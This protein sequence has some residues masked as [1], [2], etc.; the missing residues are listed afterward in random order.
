MNLKKKRWRDKRKSRSVYI[1]KNI[2][3]SKKAKKQLKLPI[4][5]T[6]PIIFTSF[7]NDRKKERLENVSI[8]LMKMKKKKIVKHV[9]THRDRAFCSQKTH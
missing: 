5:R 3:G 4:K 6:S 9:V 1:V 7:F 8:Y 2:H